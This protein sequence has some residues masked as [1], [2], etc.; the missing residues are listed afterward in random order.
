MAKASTCVVPG[1]ER[2]AIGRRICNTHKT[3]SRRGHPAGGQSRAYPSCPVRYRTCACGELYVVRPNRRHCASPYYTPR[4][5]VGRCEV[6]STEIVQR[7]GRPRRW[8]SRACYH[9]TPEYRQAK[10][11]A[12]AKRRGATVVGAYDRL[13]IF[14]RDGWRCQ[15]CGTPVPRTAKVPDHRAATVDHI[16][17]LAHGGSDTWANVRLAHFIC[18]SRR[19]VGG[20]PKFSESAA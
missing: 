7:M 16:V 4:I 2:V 9:Q 10:H 5:R 15:L 3:R 17:P 1:C 20:L 14:Q 18:N 13:A 8:C 12:K 19:G 11:R 6:C